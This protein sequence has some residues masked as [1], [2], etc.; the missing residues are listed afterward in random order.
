MTQNTEDRILDATQLLL[1]ER[2][3]SATT[4]K[5]IAEA[6]GVNEVTLFRRFENK[7]GILHALGARWGAGQAGR[8]VASLPHPSDTRGTIEALARMEIGS[9]LS[10]GGAAMR[11]AFD[12]RTVPEVSAFMGD[13][14]AE[15]LR[16]LKGYFAE[17]QAA[18]DLRDDI[19]PALMA[20][21]FFNLTSTAVMARQLLG[22]VGPVDELGTDAA[23][24]QIVSLFWDGVRMRSSDGE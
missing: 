15:N 19:G 16:G 17:R 10:D 11:L 6:A 3:Y 20:E 5:A 21:A 23:I 18:G 24:E 22:H 9:A 1:A 4:T 2:G 7:A 13:G 12:A 14:P 8:A